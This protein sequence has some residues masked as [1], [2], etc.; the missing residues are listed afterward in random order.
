[1]LLEKNPTHDSCDVSRSVISVIQTITSLRGKLNSQA[2]NQSNQPH[3]KLEKTTTTGTNETCIL[4]NNEM[5]MQKY[6]ADF[7]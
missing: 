7:Y 4:T 2:V 6:Q 3:I 5:I 1:M